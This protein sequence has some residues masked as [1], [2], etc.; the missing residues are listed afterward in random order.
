MEARLALLFLSLLGVAVC[1]D[2]MENAVAGN[3]PAVSSAGLVLDIENPNLNAVDL[4]KGALGYLGYQRYTSKDGRAFVEVLA[5]DA[6]IWSAGKDTSEATV[7]H[8][9]LKGED[10]RLMYLV[11]RWDTVSKYECFAREGREWMNITQSDF[12]ERLDALID[13]AEDEVEGYI[14]DITNPPKKA[15]EIME[16]SEQEPF[17]VIKPLPGT[18][19]VELVQ[20]ED[21]IWIGEGE[22]CTAA[23]FFVKNKKPVLAQLTLERPDNETE[24][25]YFER[26]IFGWYEMTP[27]LFEFKVERFKLAVKEDDDGFMTAAVYTA[28]LAVV[29][30]TLF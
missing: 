29:S 6:Q 25:L 13:A 21:D 19:I 16:P 27:K 9:Y 5:D 3:A 4:F 7:V 15:L 18:K 12:N 20:G 22:L 24:T 11:S 10:P 26:R 14:V 1:E 17:L 28:V 23:S 30:F 2:F 8:V